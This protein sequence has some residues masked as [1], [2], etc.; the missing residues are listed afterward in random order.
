MYATVLG[1]HD[2]QSVWHRYCTGVLACFYRMLTLQCV[3][4]WDVAIYEGQ[5]AVHDLLQ[6]MADAGQ[7]FD[8]DYADRWAPTKYVVPIVT[9]ISVLT[10]TGNVAR[11]S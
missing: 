1:H 7:V 3:V 4:G 8:M 2:M 6:S 10:D 9:T 11:Q 5:L